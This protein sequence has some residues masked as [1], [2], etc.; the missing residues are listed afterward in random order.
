M[1]VKIV[2]RRTAAIVTYD[3]SLVTIQDML[4]ALDNAGFP[5]KGKP[6]MLQ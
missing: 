6:K 4:T 1:K 5:A 2:V 3:S